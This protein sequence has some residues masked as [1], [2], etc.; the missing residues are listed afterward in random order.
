MKITYQSTIPD[1][2]RLDT[3]IHSYHPEFSR[4]FLKKHIFNTTINGKPVKISAKVLLNDNISFELEN[5]GSR[6]P[7]PQKLPINVLYQDDCILV[8]NKKA[9]R[10]VHP[11]P[12]HTQDTVLNHLLT[13]IND[14]A[15]FS[16]PERCGI[17]HR[18]DKDTSGVLVC[19]LTPYAELFLKKQFKK[20]KV[21]KKYTALVHGAILQSEGRVDLPVGKSKTSWKKQGVVNNGKKSLTTYKIKQRSPDFSLA[22]I[23]LHTG[24]THQ[25]RVHFQAL[26]HPVY[27]D[28]LYNR[29]ENKSVPL[30]LHSSELSFTHPQT[31]KT[32]T[33]RAPLPAFFKKTLKDMQPI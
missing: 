31:K 33:F 32:V 15:S 28:H 22:D 14:P 18:L 26:G 29:N 4:S 10:V 16:C 23:M 17:V 2:V 30:H 19:A 21:K 8:I 3:F 9:G 7:G 1:P 25:I 11:A 5:S 12:G 27:G 20:R 13:I 6:Q 24:R